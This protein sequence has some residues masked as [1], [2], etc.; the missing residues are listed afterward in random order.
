MLPSSS[1]KPIEMDLIREFQSLNN[2][3]RNEEAAE[4]SNLTPAKVKE[5]LQLKQSKSE[6]FVDFEPQE[7][8]M[9]P[10]RRQPQTMVTHFEF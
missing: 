2:R 10:P 7:N 6:H 9:I 8:Y 4:S 1:R 3:K 5:A